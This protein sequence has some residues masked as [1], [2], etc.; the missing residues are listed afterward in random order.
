MGRDEE[1]TGGECVWEGIPFVNL[2]IGSEGF[3]SDLD[4]GSKGPQGLIHGF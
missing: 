2:L 4:D 1:V 3:R